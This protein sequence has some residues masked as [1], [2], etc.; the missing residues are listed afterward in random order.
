MGHV[1]VPGYAAAGVC[2]N[3]CAPRYHQRPCRYLWSRLLP[4]TVL[5]FKGYAELTP[6]LTSCG[7]W[8]SGPHTL[9]GQHSR[10]GSC[11]RTGAEGELPKGVSAEKLAPPLVLR[12]G[13]AVRSTCS[14]RGAGLGFQ[15]PHRGSKIHKFSPRGSYAL[16]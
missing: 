11:G 1:C 3:V 2:A 13:S 16:F 12:D 10:A 4:G 6:L 7:T 8:E 5:M 14:C 15:H 9:P